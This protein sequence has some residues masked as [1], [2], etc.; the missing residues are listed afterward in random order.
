MLGA[1][2]ELAGAHSVNESVAVDEIERATVAEAL[3]LAGIA[4]G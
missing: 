3:L 4:S 1:S 2:D